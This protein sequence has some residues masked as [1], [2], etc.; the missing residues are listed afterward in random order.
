MGWNVVPLRQFA[1]LCCLSL[2]VMSGAATAKMT[3]QMAELNVAAADEP[4][5][6]DIH[7]AETTCRGVRLMS[8][9]W[10]WMSLVTPSL[11]KFI[12]MNST[13][14]SAVSRSYMFVEKEE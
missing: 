7:C 14:I 5:I 13:S 8:F 10:W 9:E 12:R 1:A 3:V 11:L 6:V 4:F 2:A